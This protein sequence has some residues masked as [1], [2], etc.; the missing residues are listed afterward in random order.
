MLLTQLIEIIVSV[1]SLAALPE[2]LIQVQIFWTCKWTKILA[3][4]ERQYL[5]TFS[6]ENISW[7][8]LH[9]MDPMFENEPA[10]KYKCKTIY[11]YMYNIIVKFIFS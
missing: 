5:I 2:P 9:R 3:F 7:S 1:L 4:A 6:F 10:N 11:K 8:R